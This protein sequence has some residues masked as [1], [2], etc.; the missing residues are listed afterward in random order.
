MPP[1]ITSYVVRTLSIPAK[2]LLYFSLSV[3]AGLNV[4]AQAADLE[5]GEQ[6]AAICIACHAA[7]GST[8]LPEYPSLAG[9]NA[10][11]L[12]DSMLQIRDG[13]RD[14]PLMAGQLDPMSDETI[15]DI[16]AW[17]A[18]LT[19]RQGQALDVN[20]EQGERIYRAGIAEKSVS[21]C[22]ACHGPTGIGN[23]P[24]GFPS[25]KGLSRPYVVAQL[26]AYREGGRTT[27]ERVSGMMRTTAHQLT[28]AEIEA[29]ANYVSGLY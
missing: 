10:K 22:S 29:V 3:C 21:A 25:L 4:S 7:D 16:A 24:A 27:D 8:L 19:P 28:D 14:I 12:Y 18:S 1:Q 5:A 26:T 23:A 2:R 13:E 11:Y 17:Y 6:A 15:A 9:Q 20:L